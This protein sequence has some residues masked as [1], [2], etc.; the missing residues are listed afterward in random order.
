MND[1]GV[2]N[3][4]E[5][6]VKRDPYGKVTAYLISDLLNKNGVLNTGLGDH[7]L[8]SSIY[9]PEDSVKALISESPDEQ[10]MA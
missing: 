7:A 9:L 5:V 3:G 4:E 6:Q 2:P 8:N 10:H 1:D